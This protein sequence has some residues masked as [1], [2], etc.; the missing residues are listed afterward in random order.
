MKEVGLGEKAVEGEVT[1]LSITQ[2]SQNLNYDLKTWQI[3]MVDESQSQ[4]SNGPKEN[5]PYNGKLSRSY[6]YSVKRA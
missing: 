1:R 4:Y 2:K 6:Y 3:K 5:N